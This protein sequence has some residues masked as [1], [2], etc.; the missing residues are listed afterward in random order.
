MTLH[1]P[2]PSPA[3]DRHAAF[4]PFALDVTWSGIVLRCPVYL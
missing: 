4:Q 2:E 1:F 3:L